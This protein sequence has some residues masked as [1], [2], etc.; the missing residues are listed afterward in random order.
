MQSANVDLEQST[1][2]I[3][4]DAER[5]STDELLAAVEATVVLKLVRRL[6]ALLGGRD[7]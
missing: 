5:V 6:L 4:Y 3:M 1:A 7:A 2:S